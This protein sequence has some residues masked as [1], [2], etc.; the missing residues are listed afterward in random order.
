MAIGLT[1]VTDTTIEAA[2]SVAVSSL[3]WASDTEGTVINAGA[4]EWFT[5]VNIQVSV[6]FN[7]DGTEDAEVHVRK[8]ADDGTTEDTEEEGTYLGTI[9]C[10]AGSTIIKTFQVY[11]FD[12]LD[13]GLKNTDASYTVTWG[14]QYDGYKITGMAT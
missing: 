8:S 12:Y 7:A 9:P 5:V 14:A 11:D 2:E 4:G 10:T 3:E 13:V 1:K 6:A